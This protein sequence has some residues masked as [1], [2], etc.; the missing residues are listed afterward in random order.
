MKGREFK[1]VV[2]SYAILALVFLPAINAGLVTDFT[3]FVEKLVEEP[4]ASIF[5]KYGYYALQ[6]ITSIMMW[7]PYQLWDLHRTLWGIYF[8]GLHGIN[9]I[10]LFVLVTKVSQHFELK[11]AFWIS[12]FSG[13]MFLLHPYQAE[14]VVWEACISYLLATG[15]MLTSLILFMRAIQE[16]FI[17]KSKYLYLS[18]MAFFLSLMTIEL[19]F[20]FP[21]I[22]LCLSFFTLYEKSIWSRSLNAIPYFLT[23]GF[24]LLLN[25]VIE[26]KWVGHYGSDVHLNI[27]PLDMGATIS[28]Y[29]Y[30]H[31]LFIRDW[32]YQMKSFMFENLNSWMGFILLMLGCL[33]LFAFAKKKYQHIIGFGLSGFV[34][35][36]LPISNLFFSF[37]LYGE[38]DRYGYWAMAM[39]AIALTSFFFSFGKKWGISLSLIFNIIALVL[40]IRINLNWQEAESTRKTLMES[41]PIQSEKPILLLNTPDN[42]NGLYMLRNIGEGSGVYDALK[43]IEKRKNVPEITEIYQ[44]NMTD[45]SNGC[46]SNFINTDSL[47]VEFKQ[48]GNWYWEDG[49]GA[50][51]EDNDLF[52]TKIDGHVYYLKLK[53]DPE[54]YNIYCQDSLRWVKVEL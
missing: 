22:I 35:A 21:A 18:L 32:S 47:R 15:L 43:Y 25:K 16:S 23:L 6:P 45:H 53:E 36:C 9:A 4:N 17:F 44:Y 2:L 48:W 49:I 50:T 27:V 29:F 54:K 41:F 1:W 40:V 51:N 3:G 34:L 31:I 42:F 37:L 19:P 5:K 33:L 52:N 14:A 28:K 26:G 39:L 46:K 7:I 24:Y 8:L 11:N 10:L 30:K 20:T 13:V 38:N 12:F